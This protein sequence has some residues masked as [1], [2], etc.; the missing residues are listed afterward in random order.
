MFEN[1][2]YY[3]NICMLITI[4]NKWNPINNNIIVLL[5]LVICYIFESIKI[6]E[7]LIFKIYWSFCSAFSFYL[8]LWLL[9]F[10][11]ERIF[12]YNPISSFLYLTTLNIRVLKSDNKIVNKI[13]THYQYYSTILHVKNGGHQGKF[14]LY[15]EHF[16][17]SLKILHFGCQSGS[18]SSDQVLWSRTGRYN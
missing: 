8:M 16:N 15:W 12:N 18:S 7:K 3:T 6:Y 11:M 13:S 9:I 17:F 2:I 5:L 1:R 14:Y 4:I 10:L